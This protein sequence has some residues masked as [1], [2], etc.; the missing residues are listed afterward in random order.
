MNKFIFGAKSTTPANARLTNGYTL[1]DWAMRQNCF[2]AFWARNIS[3]ENKITKEEIKFLQ[4]KDCKIVPIFNDFT[5]E[6][7]VKTNG[8][9]DAFKAIDNIKD[10][11]IPE[12]NNIAVIVEIKDDWS[13]N[14]NWM[15]SFAETLI[16][17]GYMPGFLGNTDSSLNFNFDRQCSHYVNAGLNAIYCASKPEILGEIGSWKPYAPSSLSPEDIS[18]W[19]NKKLNLNGVEYYTVFA[20]DESILNYMW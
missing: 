20:K 18:L 12:K 2:P 4:E 14:H 6:D 9:N 19:Q 10:L 3:G 5:E 7:I 8:A 16:N 17:N 13:V 11:G 1:Y 15:I